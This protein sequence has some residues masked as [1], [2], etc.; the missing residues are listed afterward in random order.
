MDRG[1]GLGLVATAVKLGHPHAAEAEGGHLQGT[2]LT[3]L[4]EGSPVLK[5]Q[6]SRRH[7]GG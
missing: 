7:N 6:L 2:K 1:D 5:G 3:L 4:H